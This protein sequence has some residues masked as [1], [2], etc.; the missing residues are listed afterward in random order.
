[1]GAGGSRGFLGLGEVKGVER[2]EGLCVVDA[3]FVLVGKEENM[4]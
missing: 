3:G 1:L 4:R 2:G